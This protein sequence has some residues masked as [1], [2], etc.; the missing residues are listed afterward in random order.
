MAVNHALRDTNGPRQ[1][2]NIEVMERVGR[3]LATGDLRHLPPALRPEAAGIAAL[4]VRAAASG[5][6]PWP[7]GAARSHPGSGASFTEQIRA[8]TGDERA[9]A[10]SGI[11]DDGL[12]E[13]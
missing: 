12:E 5:P 7:A 4:I 13:S 11:Y 8:L 9:N 2:S 1:L 3:F 10:A 6:V